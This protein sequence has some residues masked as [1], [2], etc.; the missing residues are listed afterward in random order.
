MHSGL[1]AALLAM[2][3]FPR[4]S[5]TLLATL[6]NLR[7]CTFGAQ[8]RSFCHAAVLKPT[9]LFV[10]HTI[11][12]WFYC[13]PYCTQIGIQRGL[14]EHQIALV[15]C[16]VHYCVQGALQYRGVGSK[17]KIDTRKSS[18]HATW[19]VAACYHLYSYI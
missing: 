11:Q 12:S 1:Q 13:G 6:V 2:Y 8:A 14:A 4:D 19:T 3:F 10:G 16:F 17:T 5:T 7:P 18:R 15:A 9:S